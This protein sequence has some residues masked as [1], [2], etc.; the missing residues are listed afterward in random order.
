MPSCFDLVLTGCLTC[1]ATSLFA[2]QLED[3]DEL[4]WDDGTAYP[5]PCPDV[6]APHLT[7]VSGP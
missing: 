6:V 7:P 3:D 1:L 2:L 5:E 4:I